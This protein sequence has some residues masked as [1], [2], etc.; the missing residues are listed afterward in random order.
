MRINNAAISGDGYVIKK[1]NENILKHKD[2]TIEI[3][4]MWNVKKEVMPAIR[5]ENGTI[6]Q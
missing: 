1:G 6:S 5:G 2:V 4:H 3:Q